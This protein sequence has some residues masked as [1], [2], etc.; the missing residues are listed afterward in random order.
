VIFNSVTF[1]LFLV[2]VV[3]LYWSLPRTPR[4]WLVFLA[5][6]AFYAFWRWEYLPVM[7]ASVATDYVA[8]RLIEGSESRRR[9]LGIL[10]ASLVV[11][12]GL[13]GYFKYT[14]FVLDNVSGLAAVLGYREFS[15]ELEIILPIGISF[16]TFQSM[17]YTIDVYRRF[18]PAQRNFLLF[19]CYVTFFPQL[20]AG[21]ILRASEVIWQL[22]R[23]PRFDLADISIGVRRIL[24][25]LFLKVIL[26]DNIA[27]HV[28]R[29]FQTDLAYLGAL[30]VWTLAVLFGLQI[31]FDFSAYSHIAIGAARLMGIRFPENF[32]FPY[33]ASSPREFWRRWHI[34][35]SSWI[36][37]YLYLPLSGTAVRD[38]STGGLAV[39]A[40]ASPALRRQSALLVTWVLMGLWHGA[41]WT[42]VLWG[43]WHAALI[44][45]YRLMAP[46]VSSW[47][48][49]L[50][51]YGGWALTLPLIMLGWIPFRAQSA[52]DALEM[53]SRVAE[54]RGYLTLGLRE[55]TYL[56]TGLL[57]VMTVLAYAVHRWVRPWLARTTLACC[58]AET[59]AFAVIIALVFIFLRPINQFIYFQF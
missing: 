2:I 57:L 3:C 50:R 38:E 20:V 34:S 42:F 9:R 10:I 52:S 41:N 24:V 11:N 39:A 35:L 19:G 13:L 22:D 16:Y 25:G 44:L 32:E 47:P 17:S 43:L 5:S 46:L 45:L 37:D 27:G 7:L 21:P 56:V 26:A 51:R 48:S 15:T 6:L 31:Y 8:A 18:I 49:V 1:L 59:A 28:N 14:I 23:R 40:E 58:V 54:P 36:R 53:L 33:L 55:N 12:L 4:L 29:G 30:D